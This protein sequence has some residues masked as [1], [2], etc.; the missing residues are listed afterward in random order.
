MDFFA[1]VLLLAIA[2]WVLTRQLRKRQQYRYL[3]EHGVRT[4]ARIIQ[5][6]ERRLP[7][8]RR[9]QFVEYVFD[10]A[11][12]TSVS[13]KIPVTRAEYVAADSGRTI[14]IIYDPGQPSLN[15]PTAYLA[16]KGYLNGS[17]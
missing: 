12:G 11:E 7:K 6:F 17:Q 10:T 15:R 16:R 9:R 13:Q 8:A 14:P 4:E 3:V 2:A 5:R 1:I